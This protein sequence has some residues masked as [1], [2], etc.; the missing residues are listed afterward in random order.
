ML[1]SM[2]S[3]L[4][5]DDFIAVFEIE[6]RSRTALTKILFV[7]IGLRGS[8]GEKCIGGFVRVASNTGHK[9]I[10]IP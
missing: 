2:K 10:Y 4:S 7:F 8:F 5:I 9:Y 1:R 6:I 3:R